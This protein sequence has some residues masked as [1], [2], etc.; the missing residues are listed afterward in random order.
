[1]TDNEGV[2]ETKL[3]SIVSLSPEEEQFIR[4]IQDRKRSLANGTVLIGFGDIFDSAKVILDGWCSRS[5]TFPDGKR[6]IYDFCLPGDIVCLGGYFSKIS[7]EDI[8][9][10]GEVTVADIEYSRFTSALKHVPSVAALIF[11]LDSEWAENKQK[12]AS[13]GRR[14]GKERVAYFLLEHSYRLGRLYDG[15]LEEFVMPI[16]QNDIADALGLSNVHVNRVFQEL[17]AEGLVSMRRGR[18]VEVALK[19]RD[20]LA[21]LA[22]FDDPDP[23]FRHR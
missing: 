16:T 19:D 4:S 21:R 7:D 15:A 12:L 18:S 5:Y 2:L 8:V 10:V 11:W 22:C 17:R 6:Q 3:S 20:A 13:L 23:D 9:A 14:S 1:M